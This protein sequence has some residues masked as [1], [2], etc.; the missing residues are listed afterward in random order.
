MVM[1]NPTHV[2]MH[3]HVPPRSH[4]FVPDVV[5]VIVVLLLM[6][7]VHNKLLSATKIRL[8]LRWVGGMQDNARA[9]FL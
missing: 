6:A 1:R 8:L 5:V 7:V 4:S 3:V 9:L 2:Y